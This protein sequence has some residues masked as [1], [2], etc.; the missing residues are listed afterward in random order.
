M[1]CGGIE[2]RQHSQMSKSL[3]TQITV[4]G[5]GLLGGSVGLAAKARGLC[6]RVVGLGRSQV[7]LEEALRAG[8]IDD[9]TTST[10][11]GVKGSDLIVICTPV[12]HIKGVL[13]EIMAHSAP[14][15][16]VTDVGST[17]SGI[18]DVGE[19]AQSLCGALFV[20]SHPMAG[21]DQS[22]VRFA[23][24]DLYE[25]TNC[26]VTKTTKTDMVAFARVVAFWR[27]LGARPVVVRPAR[28]DHLVA[29]VS[30]LPHLIAV[31]L[32]RAIA[33]HDE[34]K[35]LVD[36]IIGNGFRDTTRIAQ[37]SPPMWRDI[38]SENSTEINLSRTAFE[39]ALAEIMDAAA[40]DC[41]G[42]KG[43]LESASEYREFFDNR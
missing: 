31:A 24:A 23:R 16:I 10:A 17:K 39:A 26:F 3:F 34:D 20:G 38:C 14:G 18:V 33:A 12:Q 6:Q 22:G 2:D 35:N 8:A 21:S 5:V 41:A 13:G 11:D 9:F 42:L 4:V 1:R 15:T 28:H 7:S 30:H 36:G 19:R 43:M 25:D 40:S 29:L 27:A 32:I 37:G